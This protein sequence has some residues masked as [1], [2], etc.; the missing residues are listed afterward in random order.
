[1]DAVSAASADRTVRGQGTPAARWRAWSRW[2]SAPTVG[3]DEVVPPGRRLLV[4]APHPDD[5]VLGSGGL[6]HLAVRAGRAVRVLLAT[7]GQ[8]SH[9]GSS[10]WPVPRLVPARRALEDVF[11]DLIGEAP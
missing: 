10:R 4:V 9:P 6:L 3:L 5:E 11:L 7:D 8:A 1:M 2:P